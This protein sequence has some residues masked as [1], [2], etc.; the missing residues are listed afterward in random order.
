MKSS[1][2]KPN[3]PFF[4][5]FSNSTQAKLKENPPVLIRNP[6]TRQIKGP[7]SLIT[8]GKGYAC[9]STGAGPK[10]VPM[11]NIKPYHTQARTDNSTSKDT[12]TQTWAAQGDYGSYQTF[13]VQPA[14][15]TNLRFYVGVWA[16]KIVYAVEL[17]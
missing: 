15:T 6:E 10:W 9:V 13:P 14:K 16:V 3:H 7:F 17:F 11:K 2:A 1:F 8:W 5:H 4:R 12:S